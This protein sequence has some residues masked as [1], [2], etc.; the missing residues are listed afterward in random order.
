MAKPH[1]LLIVADPINKIN[2]LVQLRFV[3]RGAF[4]KLVTPL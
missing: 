4:H 1:S 2:D 3:A